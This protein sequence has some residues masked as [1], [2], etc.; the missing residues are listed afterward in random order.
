MTVCE[1]S[2][3]TGKINDMPEDKT[4]KWWYCALE[5]TFPPNELDS[6]TYLAQQ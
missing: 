6:G 2:K 5:S 4:H 3:L 1:N